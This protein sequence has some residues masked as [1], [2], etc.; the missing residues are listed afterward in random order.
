MEKS[1]AKTSYVLGVS[2]PLLFREGQL[3]CVLFRIFKHRQKQY[4]QYNMVIIWT[5]PPPPCT[6]VIILTPPKTNKNTLFS[7]NFTY[8]KRNLNFCQTCGDDLPCVLPPESCYTVS[9]ATKYQKLLCGH[10]F[11]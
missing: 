1:F 6:I 11:K 8:M 10:V 9:W 3:T 7:A 4:I 5:Y 2:P